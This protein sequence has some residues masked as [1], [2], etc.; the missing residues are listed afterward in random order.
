MIKRD[1][2]LVCVS[3]VPDTHKINEEKNDENHAIIIKKYIF[4][5]I[6]CICAYL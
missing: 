2:R 6:K 3:P 4:I 1:G 5:G